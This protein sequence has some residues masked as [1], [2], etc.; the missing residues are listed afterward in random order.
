MICINFI[1]SWSVWQ[2]KKIQ[3][4]R[5]KLHSQ[6]SPES[7]NKRWLEQYET[8][9]MWIIRLC[10]QTHHIQYHIEHSKTSV[11]I[12][13]LY[14]VLRRS[15]GVNHHSGHGYYFHSQ[16]PTALITRCGVL[17]Y[18]LG[19]YY[20]ILVHLVVNCN[21]SISTGTAHKMAIMLLT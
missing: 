20:N 12:C 13:L 17:N 15:V 7:P 10:W 14:T 5:I 6:T 16:C 4:N 1:N 21:A 3:K 8:H 19:T 18:I 11:C 9:I 2:Q